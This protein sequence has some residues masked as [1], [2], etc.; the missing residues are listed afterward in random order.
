MTAQEL[1]PIDAYDWD[2]WNPGMRATLVFIL[3]EDKVLL[4]EKLTGLGKGKINAP[5]G[6][7]EPGETS[8]SC[9]RRE[10]LEEVGLTVDSLQHGAELRFLMSDHPDIHCDAY[11]TRQFRGTPTA[12]REA[13][14][15]WCPISEIPF[16]RMWAD[17]A[18][19]LPVALSGRKVR[20]SFRFQGDR[21]LQ[22]S[23]E[24][25]E[26]INIQG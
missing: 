19:W 20:G 8:E 18:I 12:T 14:P 16:E 26:K 11:F 23:I 5:G 25:L 4:I 10:V 2:T 7:I 17:D 3:R 9:A 21:M 1:T 6:K 24:R 22:Q 13:T 15:F